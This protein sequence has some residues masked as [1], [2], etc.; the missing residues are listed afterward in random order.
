MNAGRGPLLPLSALLLYVVQ[1]PGLL[2]QPTLPGSPILSVD[3]AQITWTSV[4][5]ATG[6]DLVRGDLNALR[7]SGG[8]FTATTR[9]CLADDTSSLALHYAGVPKLG[10]AFWFLLRPVTSAEVGTYDSGDAGQAGSRDA[11][12][13]AAPSACF[14][15]VVPRVPIAILGDAA[16]TAANGVVGGS[17]T[18][19]D[20]YLISGWNVVCPSMSGTR[21]IRIAG[22]TAP[23]IVRNVRA[24]SCDIGIFLSGAPNGRVERAMATD[25]VTG[26]AVSSSQDDTIDGCRVSLQLSVGVGAS[27]S[28][29]ILIKRNRLEYGLVGIN[30]NN[31]SGCSVYGNDVLG[32]QNQGIEQGFGANPNFWDAG[33]P[34]GGNYWSNYQGADVCR[35]PAQSDC[36]APDGFGDAP[37]FVNSFKADRY[38]RMVP[39]FAEG[40]D[41]PP[42]VAITSPP[43]GSE[44]TTD[45]F[46]VT[47]TAADEG[48]GVR[49]VEVSQN[50]GPW[51][52][53]SGTTSWSIPVSPV[54]GTNSLSVRSLDHAGQMSAT[55]SLTVTYQ[56]AVWEAALQTNKTTYVPGEPVAIAFQLTN[57]TSHAVT[58]HFPTTCESFFSVEDALGTPVYD[59]R[60]HADCLFV[61]TERTWQPN[62]TVTYNF[63]WPQA[64]DAG[65]QVPAANYQIRGFMDS[66]EETPDGL[67]TVTIAP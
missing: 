24:Q 27:S 3:Y 1:S 54:G 21:G 14:S 32:N 50:G 9:L 40:D 26:V 61:F 39:D 16:F 38:P 20:P 45:P 65:Q 60:R 62:E 66:S 35:G 10:E 46:T 19:A 5:S 41:V 64:N 49:R 51:M 12:I 37:V 42:T 31:C 18:L 33:Y 57:R 36:S 22:T 2:A 25:V 67:A 52:I 47:G 55:S 8:D 28:T 15:P 6:Y 29:N 7:Q 17:G 53:A 63:T 58:L 4:P 11:E 44:V 56:A 13:E 34:G 30:L 59:D 43:P 48:S 23:F